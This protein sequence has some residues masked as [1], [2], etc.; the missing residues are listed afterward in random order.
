MKDRARAPRITL[1]PKGV[2]PPRRALVLNGALVGDETLTPVQ[3]ELLRLLEEAGFEVR[4]YVMRDVPLAHCQGCF[5][6]WTRTPGLCRT[7]GDAGR[8]IAAAMIRSDL[9]ILI[10]RITFGGY[11]SEI[12]KALDRCICLML[13]FFRRTEGEVH[14][15]KRYDRYP[16]LAGVGVLGAPDDEQE[17]IFRV[18]LE[19]N[20]HNIGG[21]APASCVLLAGASR[22]GL[23]DGLEAS[24]RPVLDTARGRPA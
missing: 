8:E 13:P 11:S 1:D 17:T 5:E 3:E 16:I 14:H 21:I 18:L 24:L 23:R 19:R 6:C 2:H 10:T 4:T 9:S 7:D 12:K 22:A 15:K 20:A